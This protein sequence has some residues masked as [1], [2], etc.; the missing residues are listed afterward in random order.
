MSEGRVLVVDDNPIVLDVLRATLSAEGFEVETEES[1]FRMSAAIR[2]HEPELILLDV[3]MPA[4]SGPRAASILQQHRYSQDIPVLFF[5]DLEVPDLE[6]LAEEAGVAGFIS[7]AT[8]KEHLVA[9]IR[10]WIDRPSSAVGSAG[11]P[12]AQDS[13]FSFDEEAVDR[14]QIEPLLAAG[15]DL[16]ARMIAAFER[17]LEPRLESLRSAAAE[18]AAAQVGDDAHFL[19]GSCRSLGARK[20]VDLLDGMEISANAGSTPGRAEVEAV[21]VE[22]GRVTRALREILLQQ[23]A[24]TG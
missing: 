22:S 21:F 10:R 24:P 7:K 4:L 1:V 19:K 20:L 15:G 13:S 12:E 23:A 11:G 16:L 14:A 17:Q 3:K 9:E 6:R 2:R 18:G 8:E 5:S